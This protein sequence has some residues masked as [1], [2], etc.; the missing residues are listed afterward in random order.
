MRIEYAS[1]RSPNGIRRVRTK[2]RPELS[3]SWSA[4]RSSPSKVVLPSNI[5][6]APS[7]PHLM[8]KMNDSAGATKN[9]DQKRPLCFGLSRRISRLRMSL[10]SDG[11]PALDS[12][13]E[14]SSKENMGLTLGSRCD[15]IPD[16]SNHMTNNG[17]RQNTS[18]QEE[19]TRRFS[20]I[21][22]RLDGSPNSTGRASNLGQYTLGMMNSDGNYV[23]KEGAAQHALEVN[24]GNRCRERRDSVSSSRS[25]ISGVVFPISSYDCLLGLENT[26]N[27]T[28]SSLP[29]VNN[30]DEWPSFGR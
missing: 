17:Q 28:K 30:N 20:S 7:V 13:L 1:I 25:M 12:S 9:L 3:R 5:S 19:T 24:F 22:K 23:E 6:H 18:F 26:C 14:D 29:V 21:S 27:K 4:P 8:N 2:A 11:Q 10:I 16:F 15:S